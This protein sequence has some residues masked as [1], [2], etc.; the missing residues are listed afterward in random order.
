MIEN[1]IYKDGGRRSMFCDTKVI[2]LDNTRIMKVLS[3][4][5][6]EIEDQIVELQKLK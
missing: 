2:F 1:Y 3:P 6:M 5:A 4:R